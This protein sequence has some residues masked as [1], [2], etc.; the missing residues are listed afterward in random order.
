MPIHA[1][2]Y[3]QW[4]GELRGQGLRWL[5]IAR[6]GI[7]LSGKSKWLRRLVLV[8]WLPLLYYVLMFFVVGRLTE[9]NTLERAQEL[10]QYQALRGLF[11]TAFTDAFVADPG[12][13]RPAI[14]A[15]LIHFFMHWTQIFCVMIVVAVVGPRLVSDD[16]QS[17][18]LALY[19][20]KPL[21][22]VDYVVG[23][24]A[25]VSFWVGAVTLAPSLVL[26][27]LSI[28]FSPGVET[29]FQTASIVPKVVVYAGF[30]MLG[31][32]APMLALS[33]LTP[34][35]RLLGFL[36][37]GCWVMSSVASFVLSQTLFPAFGRR[38]LQGVEGNWTG[39]VSFS[40]N[41]DAVGFRLFELEE[42]LRPV[43]EVSPN[44]DK[45]LRTL[46]YGH[47]W[48]LS[49]ALILGLAAASLA[50]VFRRIGRPGEAG[51][52]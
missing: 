30:L 22:R 52:R 4:R 29:L 44:A 21:T 10:W 3:G 48:R 35:P 45:L 2:G 46:S 14:W 38:G 49:L 9:L 50:L 40:K 13:Y 24:L 16:L 43:A 37:A 34:N 25:V 47:D 17:R 5:T 19:F 7:R 6:W 51:A 33:S 39:L 36:W 32:G 41:L 11:G 1:R 12:A 23:K 15:V 42:L 8:A 20:S 28:A 18:A 31:T 26:Y 27:A